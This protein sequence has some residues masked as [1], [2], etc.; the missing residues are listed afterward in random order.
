MEKK[1]VMVTKTSVIAAYVGEGGVCIHAQWLSHVQLIAT[2]HQALL[3]LGFPRQEYWSG[4]PFPR[5]KR[6]KG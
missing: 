1:L 2:P 5:G 6:R 3:S 4:L